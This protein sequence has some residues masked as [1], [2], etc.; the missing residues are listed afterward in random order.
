MFAALVLIIAVLMLLV[1]CFSP[2]AASGLLAIVFVPIGFAVPLLVLASVLFAVWRSLDQGARIYIPFFLLYWGILLISQINSVAI[3]RKLGLVGNLV[4]TGILACA[5][6]AANV[7][8]IK[9]PKKA[10]SHEKP[11]RRQLPAVTKLCLIAAGLLVLFGTYKC[12]NGWFPSPELKELR[13]QEQVLQL[14]KASSR[15]QQDA[16][17]LWDSFENE[18][19]CSPSQI[20]RS[21]KNTGEEKALATQLDKGGWQKLRVVH[22]ES[23]SDTVKFLR[24]YIYSKNTPKGQFCARLNVDYNSNYK[25]GG[26]WELSLYL[27]GHKYAGNCYGS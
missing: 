9:R 13:H 15:N 2:G 21:Y 19:Q 6:L 25:Q 23:S 10:S 22:N 1:V 18:E 27:T 16:G 14:P 8:V 24:Y 7:Y 20:V 17:C 11:G 4:L 12:F 5:A 3:E 26:P